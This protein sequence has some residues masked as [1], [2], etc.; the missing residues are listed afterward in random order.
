MEDM[1]V[2]VEDMEKHK[3]H[4]SVPSKHF[5]PAM[6]PT[7]RKKTASEASAIFDISVTG[8]EAW[9]QGKFK[10]YVNTT[11]YD[12]ATGYPITEKEESN[13]ARLDNM[14]VFDNT[15][16]NPL[17][18]DSYN[19]TG[20]GASGQGRGGIGVKTGWETGVGGRCN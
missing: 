8:A 13:S 11:T 15:E 5:V 17:N 12:P 1:R 4:R 14:T 3:L 9:E 6:K 2:L 16:D 18:F 20:V 7:G 19:E 10:E